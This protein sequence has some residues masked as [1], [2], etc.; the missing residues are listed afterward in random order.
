VAGPDLRRPNIVPG[1][2][3]VWRRQRGFTLVELI[4]V[5]V[6]IAILGAIGAARYFDRRG[7]DSAGFAEQTR[8]MLRFSQKLAIGQNRAVFAHLNGSTIALCFASTMPCPANQRVPAIGSNSGAAACAPNTWYC[9]APPATIGYAVSPITATSLCFNAQGQPG[10][11][12]GAACNTASFGGVTVNIS[13][14][15]A[16]AVNIAAE[17]GYVF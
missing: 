12:S 9:E 5:M 3:H 11:A 10:L 2:S 6:I 8:A 13:G 17:T 4:V 16:T 15:A 7:F 1:H 14:E